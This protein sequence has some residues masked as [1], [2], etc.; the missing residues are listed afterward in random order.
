MNEVFDIA[1]RM[2]N[3]EF[4]IE[5]A[6]EKLMLKLLKRTFYALHFMS[7]KLRKD[8]GFFVEL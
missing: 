8:I 3:D 2:E 1:T 5:V 6:D 7:D 4:D